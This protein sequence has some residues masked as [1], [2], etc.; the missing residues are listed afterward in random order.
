MSPSHRHASQSCFYHI[1][2]LH[3]IHGVLDE[4]MAASIA[5][6][7]VYSQLNYAN[8]VLCSSPSK[9]LARLQRIQNSLGR[10]V[11]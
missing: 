10:V 11:A 9:Y 2:A 4:C 5:A 3:H 7:L 1:R 6:A 8:S